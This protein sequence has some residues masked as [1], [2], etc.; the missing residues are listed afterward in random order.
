ML[1]RS[2]DPERTYVE[3]ILPAKLEYCVKYV[4]SHTVAMDLK[5][6]GQTAVAIFRR[7]G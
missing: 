7:N 4:R 1:S 6:I 5:I 2:N 3:E